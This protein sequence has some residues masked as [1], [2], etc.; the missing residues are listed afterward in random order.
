MALISARS[1]SPA[2]PSRD[3]ARSIREPSALRSRVLI[4]PISLSFPW[5]LE[6]RGRAF[7]LGPPPPGFGGGGGRGGG[8]FG[9][10]ARHANPPSPL[11]LS[12]RKAGGRGA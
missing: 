4:L 11:P 6:R 3:L 2:P 5:W 9:R 10:V 12:P 1:V 7:P 8:G